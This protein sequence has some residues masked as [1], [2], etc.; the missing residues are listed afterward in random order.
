M[1]KH[2]PP[3]IKEI[4]DWNEADS[5]VSVP[6]GTYRRMK[7][8]EESA[9]AI[10][11]VLVQLGRCI[12]PGELSSKS[13]TTTLAVPRHLLLE[14]HRL[15]RER[16]IEEGVR[17]LIAPHHFERTV[18]T[19]KERMEEALR[20]QVGLPFRKETEHQVRAKI[21]SILK[22][23]VPPERMSKV[24]IHVRDDSH[25]HVSINVSGLEDEDE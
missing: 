10:F 9:E 24:K 5:K 2:D 25:G 18:L 19:I 3:K 11:N 20:S 4:F 13:E 6:R 23:F 12:D 8:F 1:K 21:M 14:L 15:T 7:A 16:I 17:D 22:E